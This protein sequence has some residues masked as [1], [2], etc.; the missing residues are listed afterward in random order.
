MTPITSDAPTGSR[1]PTAV[2]DL[3]E[4]HVARYL[5][6]H[7][8]EATTL[9]LAGHETEYGDYSPAGARALDDAGLAAVDLA[10]ALG[11]RVTA[12]ASSAEKRAAALEA[13]AMGASISGAGP[14][15][16]AWFESRERAEA[17]APAGAEAA[18]G[19][20]AHFA[21]ADVTDGDSVAA[22]IAQ[23]VDQAGLTPQD[24]GDQ[25]VD[26]DIDD[27]PQMI[28]GDAVRQARP[29]ELVRPPLAEAL[30]AAWPSGLVHGLDP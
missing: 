22:A 1:T 28:D 17:A 6:L 3:A 29:R 21:R 12:L 4:R 24:D 25:A 13:G 2:D 26:G 8:E 20:G 9:G 27:E 7:P 15:V 19:L 11:A 30:S 23:A 18:A 10:Q 14:S 5:E 16:F